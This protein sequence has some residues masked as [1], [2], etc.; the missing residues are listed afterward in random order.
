[1]VKSSLQ[2]TN[3]NNIAFKITTHY[4]VVHF[5]FKNINYYC[6]GNH[7]HSDVAKDSRLLPA[8]TVIIKYNNDTYSFERSQIF[9]FMKTWFHH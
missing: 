5:M 6:I 2:T 4:F 7:N 9:Y 1:M 8:I 3:N